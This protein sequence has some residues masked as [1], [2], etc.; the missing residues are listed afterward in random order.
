MVDSLDPTKY[1]SFPDVPE[2]ELLRHN[3]VIVRNKQPMVPQ[4]TATPLPTNHLAEEDR[5]RIFNVYLRPWVLSRQFASPH[6][7][8]L[9]DID[10]A[11]TQVLAALPP[12]TKRTRLA[13]KTKQYPETDN[14]GEPFRRSYADARKDYRCGH[15][16]SKYAARVIQQFTATHISD[17][18]EKYE[19]DAVEDERRER[20]PVDT[21]WISISTVRELLAPEQERNDLKSQMRLR[22]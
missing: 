22:T 17:S 1:L 15:V 11:V 20:A 3:L 6:V 16:V 8:H 7:P 5:S 12:R 4:P 13:I 18:L 19:N 9:A 21:S 2:T 10:V 14:A